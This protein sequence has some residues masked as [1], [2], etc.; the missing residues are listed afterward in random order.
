MIVLL[1]KQNSIR[2]EKKISWVI[3]GMN[4]QSKKCFLRLVNNHDSQ[5]LT[6]VI[7][8]NM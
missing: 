3:G 1:G 4:R 2:A 8:Q 5:T 6:Q 7:Y